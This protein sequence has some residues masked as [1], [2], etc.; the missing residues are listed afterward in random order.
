MKTVISFVLALLVSASASAQIQF[1]TDVVGCAAKGVSSI[2]CS[3]ASSAL[4]DDDLM[5]AA[6]TYKS[7]TSYTP[8]ILGTA[9]VTWTKESD[10]FIATGKKAPAVRAQFWR[11][12]VTVAGS[13]T[14][15][16]FSAPG[17][18]A[19]IVLRAALFSGVGDYIP[20]IDPI[21]GPGTRGTVELQGS[22]WSGDSV[23]SQNALYIGACSGMYSEPVE[24]MLGDVNHPNTLMP[25]LLPEV[26][27]T[28]NGSLT[29]TLAY[30]L[31]GTFIDPGPLYINCIFPLNVYGAGAGAAYLPR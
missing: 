9:Q 12:H 28:G 20:Y 31:T 24:E 22:T 17:Q 15:V 29:A 1:V 23:P 26:G 14:A 6:V 5:L 19:P 2:S 11:G 18:S 8:S 16:N 21:A 7:A 4:V 27:T 13:I 25:T 30:G 10:K 3:A